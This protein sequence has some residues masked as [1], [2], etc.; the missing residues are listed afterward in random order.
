MWGTAKYAHVKEIREEMERRNTKI[1][2]FAC[3]WDIMTFC[4]YFLFL[5]LPFIETPY[6][7]VHL[8][9]P[10]KSYLDQ[11]WRDSTEPFTW[12]K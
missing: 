12:K 4:T 11:T 2:T 1:H 5:G 10:T 6:D 8:P 9:Y 3:G 7:Y